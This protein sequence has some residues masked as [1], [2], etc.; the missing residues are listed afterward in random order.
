M[1]FSQK[2]SGQNW[3]TYEKLGKHKQIQFFN[4]SVQNPTCKRTEAVNVKKQV[5]L[6]Q[7]LEGYIID[8]I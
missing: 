1:K 8:I 7:R 4:V 5:L 3:K 6:K 2:M